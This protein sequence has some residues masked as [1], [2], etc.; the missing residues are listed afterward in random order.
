M[1]NTNNDIII[2]I[3]FFFLQSLNIKSDEQQCFWK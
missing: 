3:Y 1:Q 2:I